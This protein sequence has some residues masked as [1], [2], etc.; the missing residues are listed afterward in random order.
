[1]ALH[2]L[3]TT[4]HNHLDTTANVA[5][6]TIKDSDD[7]LTRYPAEDL[8]HGESIGGQSE[9]GSQ[10]SHRSETAAGVVTEQCLAHNRR[11]TLL[12]VVWFPADMSPFAF[13]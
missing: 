3:D 4:T 5:A 2:H 6:A 13:G 12:S 7:L 11:L 1:M 8:Q 9:A 10:G